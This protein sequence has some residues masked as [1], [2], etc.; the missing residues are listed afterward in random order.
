[1]QNIKVI[2]WL[3]SPKIRFYRIFLKKDVTSQLDWT[4]FSRWTPSGHFLPTLWTQQ[5]LCVLYFHLYSAKFDE[6]V[7]IVKNQLKGRMRA[8]GTQLVRRNRRWNQ[9]ILWKMFAIRFPLYRLTYPHI[10]DWL[11]KNFI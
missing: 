1:M 8:G 11:L 10:F 7:C 5:L 4:N 9:F 6:C 3:S 2:I